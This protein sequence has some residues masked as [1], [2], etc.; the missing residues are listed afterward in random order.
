[1]MKAPVYVYYEMT[2]YLQNHRRFVKS[3][4]DE[5]LAGKDPAN[6]FCDPRLEVLNATTGEK[7]R[8]NPCGLMAWSLFNDTYAFEVDGVDVPVNST[9]IAW[10]SDA[11][12]KFAKY[13]P[14]KHEHGRVDP[15]RRYHRRKCG[16]GR[17]LHRVDANR[18]AAQ[19]S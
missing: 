3:R 15:G 9:D 13:E 6:T 19:V 14:K 2:N 7:S 17:A 12:F 18:R 5:Q 1:M 8:V 16:H 11:K 10:K 4:S